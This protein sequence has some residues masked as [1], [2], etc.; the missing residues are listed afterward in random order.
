MSEPSGVET[1]MRIRRIRERL[2]ELAWLEAQA[3]QRDQEEKTR[4]N[5]RRAAESHASANDAS[6]DVMLHHL[7]ALQLEVQSRRDLADLA[8][9][10]ARTRSEQGRMRAARVDAKVAERV[11][12]TRVEEQALEASRPAQAQMDELGMNAWWRRGAS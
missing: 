7:F 11:R 10:A 6:H 3:A 2:A 8:Q 9:K 1:L 12:D 4:E 5:A